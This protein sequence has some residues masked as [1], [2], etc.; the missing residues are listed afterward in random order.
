VDEE[1]MRAFVAARGL[2][3]AERRVHLARGSPGLAVSLDLEAYDRRR[4]A[5]LTLL[6]VASGGAPFAAWVKYTES[7]GNRAEKLEPLVRALYGLIEDVLVLQQGGGELSNRDVRERLAA[8]AGRVEFPWIR[9]AVA[10]ADEL[11]ELVRRN[12]QKNI[13]LDALVVELRSAMG[14]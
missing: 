12:I 1:E 8:I 3:D 7:A 6:E 9:R 2:E 5:M 4:A 14:A 13:A 10:K 11:A